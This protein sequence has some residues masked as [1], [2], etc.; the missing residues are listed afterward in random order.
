MTDELLD[1]Q[2]RKGVTRRTFLTTALAVTGLAASPAVAGKLQPASTAPATRCRCRG[3]N[4][5]CG[6]IV[7]RRLTRCSTCKRLHGE[8]E[9]KWNGVL[10]VYCRCEVRPGRIQG[11]KTAIVSLRD[12]CLTW[13]PTTSHKD[14][15]GRW[16]HVPYFAGPSYY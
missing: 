3:G 9:E 8:V 14:P 2:G 15:D 13:M 16:W 10:P 11:R 6:E 12:D 5:D 7:A 4:P 1:R